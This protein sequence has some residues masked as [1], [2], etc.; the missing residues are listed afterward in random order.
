ME[1][2][3]A[4]G[5]LVHF[6]NSLTKGKIRQEERGRLRKEGRKRGED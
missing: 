3:F 1:K 2:Y 4:F 5:N 6:I